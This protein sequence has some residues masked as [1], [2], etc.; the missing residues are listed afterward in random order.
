[1]LRYWRSAVYFEREHCE[2]VVIS[3][4]IILNCMT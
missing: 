2:N 3:V 1:M 4:I